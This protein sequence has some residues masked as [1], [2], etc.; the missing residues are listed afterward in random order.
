ML[1]S[2][3]VIWALQLKTA[4]SSMLNG[5]RV[6]RYPVPEKGQRQPGAAA[7]LP[8]RPLPSSQLRVSGLDLGLLNRRKHGQESS[9]VVPGL[10]DTS[11]WPCRL[12]AA[13]RVCV[14]ALDPSLA[15][16]GLG[17]GHFTPEKGLG[18]ACKSFDRV[19]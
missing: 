19:A 16:L 4:H 6:R 8:R 5:M 7:S 1:R 12:R 2:R 11:L 13:A 14:G 3:R 15:G 17:V 18:F 10:Y 9:R